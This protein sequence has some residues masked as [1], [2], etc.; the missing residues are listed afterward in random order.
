MRD[1][2]TCLNVG[3]GVNDRGVITEM[4]AQ[5]QSNINKRD[6]YKIVDRLTDA[7]GLQSQTT[8]VLKTVAKKQI[9]F[10]SPEVENHIGYLSDRNKHPILQ[11]VGSNI[12]MNSQTGAVES[13]HGVLSKAAMSWARCQQPLMLQDSM[14]TLSASLAPTP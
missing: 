11:Y 4:L 5:N 3:G 1:P 2:T 13:I 12:T 6:G 7:F 10:K 9:S 14:F 8:S